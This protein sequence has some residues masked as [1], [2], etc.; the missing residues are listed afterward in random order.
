MKKP[1]KPTEA[2]IYRRVSLDEQAESGHGL[3]AQEDACRAYAARQRWGIIGVFT[4]PGVSGGAKL[5][6]RPELLEAIGSLRRGDVLLV[7]KRDRLGRLDPVE[8]AII[9]K[10]AQRRGARVVSVA[11]EG[12]END[13]PS[14]VLMRT[15]IDAFGLYER[16]IIGA[17]TKSALAA[18]RKRGEKTGGA[19]PFGFQAGLPRIGAKGLPVPTLE[20]C[21][22]E[23]AIID[24]ARVMR[25]A[26]R[27]LQAIASQFNAEGVRRRKGA[28]W[29]RAYVFSLLKRSA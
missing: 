1:I 2:A 17:R 23:Q 7:A 22:E 15:M 3:D 4:D 16:L 19:I 12:T 28:E 24:Q 13:D 9:E 14:N 10:A 6:D 18:K 8:M 27:S 11:G 5:Q 29:D 20:P 26:G 21:P 25:E